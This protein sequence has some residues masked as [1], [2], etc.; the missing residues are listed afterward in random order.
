MDERKVCRD[1]QLQESMEGLALQG[2][3]F[4][5]TAKETFLNVKTQELRKRKKKIRMYKTAN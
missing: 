1:S 4:L 3:D 5:K 2:K